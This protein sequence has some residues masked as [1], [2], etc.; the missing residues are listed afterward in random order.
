MFFLRPQG[1]HHERVSTQDEESSE[2][3]NNSSNGNQQPIRESDLQNA[4]ASVGMNNNNQSS[5]A[6]SSP[7]SP[8]AENNSPTQSAVAAGLNDPSSSS[9]N[10]NSSG[11]PTN[12]ERGGDTGAPT[13][14]TT[15]EQHNHYITT[16]QQNQQHPPTIIRTPPT[17]TILLLFFLLRLWIEAIIQKDIGLI[18]IS[19]MGTTWCYRWY[20]IRREAEREW[21]DSVN[22]D[23]NELTVEGEN[24]TTT[25]ANNRTGRRG[26]GSDAA[27]DYDPDLG[28]MSF[29]AQ[30]ALAILES[31]RQMFENGGYGGNDNNNSENDGLGVTNEAKQSWDKYEWGKCVETTEKLRSV[32]HK[33]DSKTKMGM[34]EDYGSVSVEDLSSSPTA[35]TSSQH[36]ENT[37]D[38]SSL[39]KLEE[40]GLLADEGDDDEEPSCSICLC[41]YETGETVTKLPCN[42]IYHESCLTSWTENHVRCPLCNYDLMTGFQQPESTTTTSRQRQNNEAEQMAFRNMALSALGGRRIRARTSRRGGGGGRRGTRYS[43]ALAAAE[44]SIV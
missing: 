40:G 1:G 2:A 42:H 26:V 7:L 9:G 41:E 25:I 29:Q 4:L 37:D 32:I 11:S 36:T 12:S 16:N 33:S 30:L 38:C 22:A 19:L 27:M 6:S 14:S 3:T 20:L 35:T 18:F 31:Q 39:S 23:D 15:L 24:N 8:V 10:N 5:P 21:L 43:S 13:E 28:L 34:G 44:D 17:C